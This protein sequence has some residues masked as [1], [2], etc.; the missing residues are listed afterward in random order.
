MLSFSKNQAIASLIALTGCT[1][2]F[3]VP[4]DASAFQIRRAKVTSPRVASVPTRVFSHPSFAS[5][6]T[7]H[8]P[9]TFARPASTFT[10]PARIGGTFAH[11]NT[12]GGTFP[13]P[14]TLGG[15]FSHP[16]SIGGGFSHPL[17]AASFSTHPGS[18]PRPNSIGSASHVPGT[19]RFAA[20]L[21]L[22]SANSIGSHASHLPGA[23]N[24]GLSTRL[25][26]LQ[27]SN[28]FVSPVGHFNTLPKPNSIGS[29][30]SRTANAANGQATKSLAHG[31]ARSLLGDVGKV[32]TGAAKEVGDVASNVV[33]GHPDKIPGTI[34]KDGAKVIGA[35][36]KVAGDIFAPPPPRLPSSAVSETQGSTTSDASGFNVPKKGTVTQA[37]TTAQ[38]GPVFVA[39]PKAIQ[40]LQLGLK[41]A[42]LANNAPSTSA[43]AHN[44]PVFVPHNKAMQALQLSLNNKSLATTTS[45]DSA[46][47]AS[48]SQ[49]LIKCIRAPCP[50]HLP[51][52]QGIG[53]GNGQGTGNKGGSVGQGPFGPTDWRLVIDAAH[54]PGFGSPFPR[55]G[56]TSI[57][58]G[59]AFPQGGALGPVG[60]TPA[61]ASETNVTQQAS[62]TS[63]VA[64]AP[65]QTASL[66]PMFPARIAASRQTSTP[67]PIS[68]QAPAEFSVLFQQN[69]SATDMAAFLEAYKVSIAEGPSADGSY[70]LRL[71]TPLGNDQLQQMVASMKGQDSVVSNAILN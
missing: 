2:A 8:A 12:F 57:G 11:P 17:N 16:A 55:I 31:N 47:K 49:P 13:R 27:R 51:T 56:S 4:Q 32:F 39:P 21:N 7:V 18:F 67:S 24:T 59:S 41:N 36:V 61:V 58:S 71:E 25:A 28:G 15:H 68:T 3:F 53:Q 14:G 46:L 60:S 48:L 44:G 38:S 62:A 1:A 66:Q 70:K 65:V 50:T 40:A 43:S 6:A 19:G 63:T 9:R 22:P 10:R 20:H 37:P 5:R 69:V 34:I 30:V 26:G 64:Q 29:G 54:A 45:S 42:S 23:A 52:G 33:T 35:E